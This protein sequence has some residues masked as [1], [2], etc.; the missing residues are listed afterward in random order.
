[1]LYWHSETLLET[2][3]DCLDLNMA[4]A[5]ASTP[6]WS[7]YRLQLANRMRLGAILVGMASWQ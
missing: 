2:H 1:M 3:Y 5:A 7:V 4:F 6:E